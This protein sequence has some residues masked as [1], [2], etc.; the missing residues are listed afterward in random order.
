MIFMW[1]RMMIAAFLIFFGGARGFRSSAQHKGIRS[2]FITF[3]IHNELK[4]SRDFLQQV[5]PSSVL[6][7]TTTDNQKDSGAVENIKESARGVWRTASSRAED[8][9]KAASA[10]HSG[11]V[12]TFDALVNNDKIFFIHSISAAVF[13]SLLLFV[14]QLLSFGNPIL[15]FSYQQWSVFILATSFITFMAPTLDEKSKSLLSGTYKFMCLGEC[16]LYSVEVLKSLGKNY[17]SIAYFITDMACL[18]LFTI[19]AA[20]YFVN[21]SK[22]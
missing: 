8:I 3:K 17:Y 2:T 10:P 18:V 7:S 4:I 9:K 14:P 6:H 5:R 22:K 15:S 1:S 19:L 21:D 20:G 13:G 11:P 16:V 12:S